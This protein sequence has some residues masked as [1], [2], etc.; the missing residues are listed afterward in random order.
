[1]HRFNV[2]AA[3]FSKLWALRREGE[4]SED[5]ILRRLLDSPPEDAAATATSVPETGGN[6]FI[7]ATYGVR[8]AEGFEIFRTYK[9][10]PYAAR[11]VRGRWV[12]DGGARP[13]ARSYDSLNQLSQ[14]VIDGNENAW[15]F[16]FFRRPDGTA[17]RI[18]E[19]RDPAL[20]QK[21][22]R[23]KRRRE[24]V[25]KPVIIP[26]RERPDL[27]EPPPATPAIP[28]VP[29][30]ASTASQAAQSKPRLAPQPPP[31]PGEPAPGAGAGKPWEP[32]APKRY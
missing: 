6:D 26:P 25:A 10:R 8:F 7:D 22:P 5:Q 30:S 27:P 21:R 23:R 28:A 29:S 9:G 2:S 3:V 17:S 16:W 13:Y 15:M 32:A 31:G 11:V 20:V 18:T 24:W 14:A 4:Q 12:L 19:L 1:M